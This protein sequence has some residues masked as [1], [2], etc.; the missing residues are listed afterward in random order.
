MILGGNGCGKT[1]IIECIKYALTGEC[2]PGS[3]RGKNFVRD[4]KINNS[5]EILGQIKLAVRNIRNE[6]L[7]VCRTLKVGR[8]RGKPSFETLDSTISYIDEKG[9]E[10]VSQRCADVDAILSRFMGVSKAIIN[11]VLFCHQED[12]Y[13][14]MDESK[15]LKEKFDAIFGISEYNRCVD[16]IIKMRKDK[17]VLLKFKG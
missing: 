10:S 2:P 9:R 7:C 4:P 17:L 5:A 1:T 6:G 16:R 11:N 13:W 14:P 12:A 3:D 8:K 15:K